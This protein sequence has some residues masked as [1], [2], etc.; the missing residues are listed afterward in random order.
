MKAMNS[1]HI[2]HTN[3][4]ILSEQLKP[5]LLVWTSTSVTLDSRPRICIFLLLVLLVLAILLLLTM[6]IL[7]GFLILVSFKE[8]TVR[9]FSCKHVYTT[10]YI[11]LFSLPVVPH[12]PP[13]SIGYLHPGTEAWIKKTGQTCRSCIKCIIRP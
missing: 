3:T 4:D 8:E 11:Y 10:L 2:I 6:L 12:L 1:K 7:P 9:L 5:Y 13:Q